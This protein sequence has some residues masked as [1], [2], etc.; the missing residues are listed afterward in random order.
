[1]LKRSVEKRSLPCKKWMGTGRSPATWDPER[2]PVQKREKRIPRFYT[3]PAFSNLTA[4]PD[5]VITGT[6]RIAAESAGDTE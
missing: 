6:R 1:M 4:S 2:N 5:D 3:S